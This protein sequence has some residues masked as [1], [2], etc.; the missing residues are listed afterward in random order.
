VAQLRDPRVKRSRLAVASAFVRWTWPT[1][2]KSQH[3]ATM[4]F[5]AVI[6]REPEE[7]SETIRD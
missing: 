6:T 1:V 4:I 7:S 2:V 3:F 5:R